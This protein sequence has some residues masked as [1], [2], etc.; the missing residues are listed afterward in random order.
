[1]ISNEKQIVSVDTYYV[2]K[3]KN[4]KYIYFETI[5]GIEEDKFYLFETNDLM[6]AFTYYSIKDLKEDYEMF[7]R[8][9]HKFIE[10]NKEY[11]DYYDMNN[12]EIVG[13]EK[14]TETMIIGIEKEVYSLN[15]LKGEQ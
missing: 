12:I 11:T 4:G 1:M 13:F 5:F 15:D 9:F 3:S 2:F 6:Q 8:G 7:M 10:N 14:I